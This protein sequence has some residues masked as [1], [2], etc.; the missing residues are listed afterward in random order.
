MDS[1]ETEVIVRCRGLCIEEKCT[2]KEVV[3][4]ECPFRRGELHFPCKSFETD[5]VGST[6]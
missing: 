1:K 5:M 4:T 2:L 6:S 3:I